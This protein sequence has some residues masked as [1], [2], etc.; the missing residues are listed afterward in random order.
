MVNGPEVFTGMGEY[1]IRGWQVFCEEEK[2]R[3]ISRPRARSKQ[4]WDPAP[5]K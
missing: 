4:Q 5:F 1:G 2:G 3:K